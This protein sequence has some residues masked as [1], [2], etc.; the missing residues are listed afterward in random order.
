MSALARLTFVEIDDQRD[1][2]HAEP[3][4]QAVLHEVRDGARIEDPLPRGRQ[5]RVDRFAFAVERF[6]RNVRHGPPGACVK[7]VEVEDMPPTGAGIGFL[8]K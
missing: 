7:D 8:I 2:V 3:R 1:A 6:E 4:A 5:V